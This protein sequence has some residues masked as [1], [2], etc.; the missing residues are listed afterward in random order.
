MKFLGL[1]VPV[2][3]Y[4]LLID[5][6]PAS[7]CYF[8]VIS[9]EYCGTLSEIPGGNGLSIAPQSGSRAPCLNLPFP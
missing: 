8:R 5:P 4:G 6:C 9:S 2:I 3:D 7:D 1:D